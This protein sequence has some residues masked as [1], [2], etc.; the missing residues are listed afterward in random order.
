MTPSNNPPSTLKSV[1]TSNWLIDD[2]SHRTRLAE[3]IAILQSKFEL[4][5]SPETTAGPGQQKGKQVLRTKDTHL[6]DNHPASRGLPPH[7]DPQLPRGTTPTPRAAAP[8]VQTQIAERPQQ[9]AADER[10]AKEIR[11]FEEAKFHLKQSKLVGTATQTANSQFQAINS[12]KADGSNFGDWYQ[13][14]AEVARANLKMAHF[15]FQE[16]D[17]L[18]YEKIG[19]VVLIASINH[20]LVAEMQTLPTCFAMFLA[21]LAKFKTLSRAA[22]MSIFY[23]FRRFKFDPDGHNASIASTMRDLN[24]EW[25]A[26]NVTFGMD[27]YQGFVLQAAVMES[28]APYKKAFKLRVKNTSI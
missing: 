8:F 15:F 7:I 26:I 17:N 19:R 28:D 21:L 24:A 3:D 25:L 12:L 18:T 27:A 4:P 6:T 1:G 2:I 9:L 20:S 14:L 11:D 23:K 10:L 13:N 16:C 5:P 22:Q